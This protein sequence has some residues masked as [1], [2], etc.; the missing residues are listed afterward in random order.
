[1]WRMCVRTVLADTTSS[2]AICA[3]VRLLGRYLTTR[4]SA[5]LN[6]MRSGAAGPPRAPAGQ[7]V[8]D[9]RD[10]RVAGGPVLGWRSSSSRLGQSMNGRTRPSGSA[11]SRAARATP[12][13]RAGRRGD[14]EPWRPAAVPTRAQR[15]YS[16]GAAPSITG[17]STSTACSGSSCSSSRA[18]SAIRIPARSRCSGLNRRA[19]R[20]QS[21]RRPSGPVPGEPGRAHRP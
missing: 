4:S 14:H 19:P 1:M 13:R 21:P 20:A 3:A 5:S 8:E 18:A 11:S 9:R 7:D 2:D 16:A 6:S 10:Q 17:A 15:S 12:R